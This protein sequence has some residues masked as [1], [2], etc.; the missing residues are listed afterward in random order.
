MT[1]TSIPAKPAPTQAKRLLPNITAGLA[2]GFVEV[3]FSVS[4]AS[5]IFS[6]PMREYLPRGITIVLITS[7]ISILIPAL[8]SSYGG[9][10]AGIQEKSAGIKML[11]IDVMST[12][13][14][15]R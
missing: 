9:V 15:P 4:L 2:L 13:V 8:F 3:I 1:P 11:I 7:I 6:G 10:I 14:I 12:I 5:L